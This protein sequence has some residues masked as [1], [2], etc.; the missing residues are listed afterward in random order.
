MAQPK[1]K[2]PAPPTKSEAAPRSLWRWAALLVLVTLPILAGGLVLADWWTVLPNDAQATYVGR[3]SCIQCHKG[4]YEAWHGSPHDKAMD[5]ATA[6]TVLGDFNDATLENHGVTSRAFKKDG[7]FYM[8]AEGPDGQMHDYEV[9]FVFGV[10]PL[11]Q[12]LA[13]I[14]RPADAKENELGR[15]QVLPMTWDTERHEWYFNDPPD[16]F[17]ERIE[18]GDQLHWTGTAQNWNRMCAR[19]HSTNLQKNFDPQTREY[20]TTF[21]EIDVS[22]EAC[23]GPGSLHVELAK[24]HSLFWD[25]KRGYALAKLKGEDSTAQIETCATCHVRAQRTIAPDF[26]PGEPLYDHFVNELV[27]EGVYYADG[28][29][30]D[31]DYVFGSFIQSKMYHKNIRCTDCHN[32]HSTKVKFDDNRLCTSCHQHP[33][34]KYDTPEHHR[35]QVGST[36]ASCVDCHMPHTTYMEVD[37]RR[38]HSIR[39]PR[40]DLSVELGT[41]NACTGCHIDAAKLSPDARAA[42]ERSHTREP[43]DD[44]ASWLW[45]GREAKDDVVRNE[46]NDELERLNV[47]SRDHT[48]KWYGTKTEETPHFAR[49]LHDAWRQVP[50]AQ[51]QEHAEQVQRELSDVVRNPEQ[52]AMARASALAHMSM[53]RSPETEALVRKSLSDD[54][55]LVRFAAL[56]YYEDPIRANAQSLRTAQQQAERIAEA[57]AE[58]KLQNPQTKQRVQAEINKS[59]AQAEEDGERLRRLAKAPAALLDD[60]SALVRSEAGHVLAPVPGRLLDGRQRKLLTEAVEEYAAGLLADDDWAMSHLGLGLLYAR[61]ADS[62]EEYQK[63]I[64]AYLTAM[65]VEPNVT[66]PRT[67]LADLLERR[68]EAERDPGKFQKL[69]LDAR[70]LRREEVKL[71][72]REARLLPDNPL[73]QFRYG[74]ALASVDRQ[75]E[76]LEV[77]AGVRRLEPDWLDPVVQMIVVYRSRGEWDKALALAKEFAEAHPDD[78]GGQVVLEE[79]QKVVEK[80]RQRE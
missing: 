42:I 17:D 50:P 43:L 26:T 30:R 45:A 63:A 80:L 39:I 40:P 62:P 3:Q 52:S 41:P 19:C 2:S 54:D 48:R 10:E 29:V 5:H 11:Q 55:P 77:F 38:D 68:A 51:Q 69:M 37:P 35:H 65:H 12:Y 46:I 74:V 33:V 72:A 49:A 15:L 59:L 58:A 47:W 21:S 23:H 76:A 31:E 6:E 24:R 18:P 44:Y 56:Q 32:P 66:G 78:A 9:K 64:D 16:V 28:Q 4:Q 14:K 34:S 71:M 25:R 8:N 13:E 67:N 70:E 61:R 79:I 27:R 36:G 20:H 57:L 7:K 75:D 73:V 1:L 60:P 53:V 22:C